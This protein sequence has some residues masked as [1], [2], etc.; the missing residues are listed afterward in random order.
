MKIGYIT[1]SMSCEDGWG[2]YS[3]HI[4]ESVARFHEVRVITEKNVRNE[5]TIPKV[6]PLLPRCGFHPL[7]QLKVFLGCMKYFRGCDLIHSMVEPFAPGAALAS[8]FIGAKFAMT[9]HGTYAVAP[10]AW[11][12][13]RR[14]FLAFALK[15]C[16]IST[17]GSYATEARA[18]ERVKF[19][20]CRFISNG[21][22]TREFRPLPDRKVQN[23]LLTTGGV[24]PRKGA[25]LVV[26]ALG[27]L[28]D[29]FP[30]LC[31]KIVGDVSKVS[32]VNEVKRMAQELGVADRVEFLGIIPDK[33]LI[34]LYGNCLAFVLAA[35]I[36]DGQFEGFPMVYFEANGCGAPVITTRGFGSEYVVQ[37]G[38]NGFLVDVEDVQGL[39]NAIRKI[40]GNSELQQQMSKYSVQRACEHTW[41][42]MV[43]EHLIPMYEDALVKN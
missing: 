16:A 30:D 41:D 13:P 11:W 17:T 3:K 28:K 15:R 10:K 42:R 27:M 38:R 7:T 4:I 18:R 2:R 34:R 21:V 25:D 33:E 14:W 6:Y 5:T 26:R 8:I 32:F 35:R 24:K 29:E 12:N 9:L 19:G 20:E 40:A 39:A 37:E 1:T 31:Y 36:E 22:D 43:E 23:F